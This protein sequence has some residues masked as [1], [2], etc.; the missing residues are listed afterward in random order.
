[1]K[2]GFRI[3]ASII[4]ALLLGASLFMGCAQKPKTLQVTY[5]YK[6]GCTDCSH[7]Q[8]D[9]ASL[10]KEFPGKVTVESLDANSPEAAEMTKRLGFKEHGLV[11]RSARGAVLWKATDHKLQMDEVREQLKSHLAYQEAS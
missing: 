2:H 4:P 9:V 1:M 3:S 5:Y 6:P 10:E 7:A 11:I 8:T